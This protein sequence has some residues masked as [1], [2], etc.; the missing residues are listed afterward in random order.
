MDPGNLNSF[1]DYS[2][3]RTQLSLKIQTVGEIVERCETMLTR[4]E[5]IFSLLHSSINELV[6]QCSYLEDSELER[7]RVDFHEAKM[8]VTKV[9]SLMESMKEIQSQARAKVE[10]ISLHVSEQNCQ[11]EV[12]EMKDLLD[13]FQTMASLILENRNRF[14]S[15]VVGIKGRIRTLAETYSSTDSDE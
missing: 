4:Q 13:S 2:E 1:P 6:S 5:R 7:I 15:V 8:L 9:K 12:M 10:F 11:N 14:Q 3:L